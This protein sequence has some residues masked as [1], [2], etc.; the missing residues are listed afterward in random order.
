VKRRILPDQSAAWPACAKVLLVLAFGHLSEM[1][2]KTKALFWQ[3]LTAL[4]Q[5]EYKEI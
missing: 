5:S 4:E 2:H 3:W 1:R